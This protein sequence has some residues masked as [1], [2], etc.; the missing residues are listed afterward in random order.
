MLKAREC[1]RVLPSGEGPKRAENSSL[2]PSQG[3]KHGL[4]KREDIASSGR[5]TSSF[6]AGPGLGT[7][8]ES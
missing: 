2:P 5:G 1:A 7:S 6:T 3:K 8:G 4:K